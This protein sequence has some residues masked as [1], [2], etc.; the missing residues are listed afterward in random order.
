MNILKRTSIAC[1][2]AVALILGGRAVSG[3]EKN[4]LTTYK[5]YPTI[6]PTRRWL[7]TAT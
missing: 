2:L 4:V 7:G 6:G 1:C 5:I 3:G